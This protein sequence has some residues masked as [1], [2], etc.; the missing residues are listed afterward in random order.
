M[1]DK[2]RRVLGR[3]ELIRRVGEQAQRDLYLSGEDAVENAWHGYGS[4]I[5]KYRS[6]G[7]PAHDELGDEIFRDLGRLMDW[8]DKADPRRFGEELQSRSWAFA[9]LYRRG[10]ELRQ[11]ISQRLDRFL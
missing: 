2:L 6:G 5:E 1:A 3:P 8:A 11:S 4:L 7:C 10:R 9:E